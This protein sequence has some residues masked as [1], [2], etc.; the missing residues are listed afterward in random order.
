MELSWS[1]YLVDQAGW[2]MFF[3]QEFTT[4]RLIVCSNPARV[5]F[6]GVRGSTVIHRG[7]F[8]TSPLGAN[9]DPWGEVVPQG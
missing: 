1:E 9:F 3:V 7:P 4:V 2:Q 5:M 8:L 6:W